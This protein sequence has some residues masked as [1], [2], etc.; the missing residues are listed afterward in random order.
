LAHPWSLAF[1]DARTMLVTERAGRLRVIRDG[2][3]LPDPAWQAPPP[4]GD[5]GDALHFM[6]LHPQ[7][8]QNRLVYLSLPKHGDRGS[9]LAIVRGR[10]DGTALTNVEEIFAA[11]AWETG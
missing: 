6:A 2:Q 3:L 8:D 11:D 7:F 10:F 1:P 5:G 4:P 9:T